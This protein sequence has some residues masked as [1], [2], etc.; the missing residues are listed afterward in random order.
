GLDGDTFWIVAGHGRQAAYVRNLQAEPRVRV[1]ARGEWRTG[2][3][4]V[5]SPE[6]REGES[7]RRR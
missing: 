3:A 1:K 4:H 2:T 6:R 5:L 7:R